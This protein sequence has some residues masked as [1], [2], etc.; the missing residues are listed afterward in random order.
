VRDQAPTPTPTPTPAPAPALAPT[1]AS[2]PPPPSRQGSHG[3]VALS[4]ALG[5]VTLLG[6]WPGIPAVVR[7]GLD[8]QPGT[9]AQVWRWW[10][11]AAVHLSPAHLGLNLLALGLVALLG[12]AAAMPRRA[13]LAWALAWPLTQA[14]MSAAAAWPGGPGAAIA[15]AL[16]HYGGLSGVL[17]AG[18]VIVALRLAARPS[19]SLSLSPTPTPTPAPAPTPTPTHTH[20]HTHPLTRRDRAVGLAL[21]AGLALKLLIEAP[22]RPELRP[23]ALLGIAVAPLAHGC[24]VLAG[25]LALGLVGLGH[26]VLPRR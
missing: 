1:P 14:L 10:T 12:Q 11:A 8:W 9:T 2:V 19:L 23:D 3:W 21:L 13:A 4:L 26:R 17:H 16:P 7:H 25:V 20:T 24:G 6:A 15:Q 22:W 18:V 5:L